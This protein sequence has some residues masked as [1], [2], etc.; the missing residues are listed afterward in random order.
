MM[1]AVRGGGLAAVLALL[2]CALGSPPARAQEPFRLSDP[3]GVSRWAPVLRRVVVRAE[4]AAD[5]R[6]VTTLGTRTSEGTQN[7]VL[8]LSR[9]SAGGL[10]VRVR[11]A[12]LPNGTTGWVPRSALGEYTEVRTHL[13]VDRR[14]L[15]LRLRRGGRVVF[16][17]QIGIGRS[18]WPTPRGEFYVR[19]RIRGFSAPMYGPLAFG[20]SARSAVLTDWPGGGFIGI[21]GTDQ[22]G[23][24]PGRVSHGCIRLRNRDILRLGR[25]L[26]VGTPVTIR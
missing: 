12:V 18:Q 8:A 23:L 22:P 6:R 9:V 4:P 25:M 19:N 7:L 1:R 16:R 14:R 26:P 5:A 17:A 2:A 21:H 20:L 11:L 13:I 24:L 3:D 10:W 15:R